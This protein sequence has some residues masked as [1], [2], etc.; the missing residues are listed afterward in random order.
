MHKIAITA[1]AAL[2]G[3]TV[4]AAA[5]TTPRPGSSS[6][7]TPS[8]TQPAP[9]PAVNPLTKDVVSNID[10]TAVY[11]TN[12]DKI[13]HVSEVL[14]DP[15]SKKIDR[16]VVTAGGVLGIGG[17][18]VAI[19]VDEFKWDSQQGGFMLGM[20]EAKL[21]SMPEWNESGTTTTGSS[22]PSTPAP[23][24]AAGNSEKK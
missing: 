11:G 16:L 21:K 18:R 7:S 8:A 24:T 6:P 9:K 2:A 22:Q 19:P 1:V 20:T 14:M 15:Q 4:A 5:Q 3:M 12:K 23:S 10:G 13:G 17:H